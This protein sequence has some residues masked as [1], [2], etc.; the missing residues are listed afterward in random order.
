[1]SALQALTN[2]APACKQN[3]RKHSLDGVAVTNG[4]N[5]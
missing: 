1:M 3:L 4:Y 5:E 2:K